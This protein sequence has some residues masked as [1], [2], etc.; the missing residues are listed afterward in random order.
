MKN[1][2]HAEWSKRSLVS[3]IF[4]VGVGLPETFRGVMQTAMIVEGVRAVSFLFCIFRIVTLALLNALRVSH[5][6]RT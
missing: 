3:W 5:S 6:M 2:L 4:R 1:R